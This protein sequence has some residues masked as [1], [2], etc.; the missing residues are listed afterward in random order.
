M[1][2]L[3]FKLHVPRAILVSLSFVVHEARNTSVSE[4]NGQTG[5]RVRIV[6]DEEQWNKYD[7]YDK[8][9]RA[10][11]SATPVRFVRNV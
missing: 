2:K 11:E 9:Q 8:K 5:K 6:S 7:V 4:R 1:P 10:I 3:Y